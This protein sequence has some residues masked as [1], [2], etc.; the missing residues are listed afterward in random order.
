VSLS[1]ARR[2]KEAALAE[3]HELDAAR[4]RGELIERSHLVD[5]LLRIRR[6]V[7]ALPR[8]RCQEVAELLG[9][10]PRQAVPMLEGV[11]DAI[12]AELRGELERWAQEGASAQIDTP[13]PEELPHRKYL[14]R[15]GCETVEELKAMDDLTLVPGIGEARAADLE[16]WL[17]GG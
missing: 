6:I 11:A 3:K 13:L 10:E 14:I 7:D 17:D 1:D 12:L 4:R 2:R 9:I 5:V 16:G 8:R 15:F